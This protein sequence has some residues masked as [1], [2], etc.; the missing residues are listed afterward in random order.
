MEAFLKFAPYYFEY[1]AQN[2]FH[3]LPTVLSQIFGVYRLSIK[4]TVTGKSIK[5]DIMVT[6]NLF[7]DR[8]IT[9]IFDLKGSLRNRLVHKESHVLQDE[10]LAEF[11][12]KNPLF[13][14]EHSKKMLRA[15]IWNDTLFLSKLDVMD[16]SLIVGVDED[17]QEL[18]VGIVGKRL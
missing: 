17:R 7:Y 13:L 3:S 16:Y 11:M 10:N 12:F 15:S 14:R 8:N 2:L 4:N 9:R 18:I 5:Y 6:E 1:V